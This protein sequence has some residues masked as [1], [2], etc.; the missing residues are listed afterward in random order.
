MPPLGPHFLHG[1]LCS[2]IEM[3]LWVETQNRSE[4]LS[5]ILLVISWL[6][7]RLTSLE[8]LLSGFRIRIFKC[9]AD[10]FLFHVGVEEHALFQL[11]FRRVC[12]PGLSTCAMLSGK[13]QLAL[14]KIYIE[15]FYEKMSSLFVSHLDRK[16]LTTSSRKNLHIFDLISAW[17]P[18]RLGLPWWPCPPWLPG[19]GGS[20]AMTS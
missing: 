12:R 8:G 13:D 7:E 16:M 14:I 3:C 10:A 1:K 9:C 20:S 4:Y 18:R 5:P 6:S 11:V 19:E 2:R 17:L 15:D